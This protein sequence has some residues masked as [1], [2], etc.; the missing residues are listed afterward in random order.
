MYRNMYSTIWENIEVD[1][2]S[3]NCLELQSIILHCFDYWMFWFLNILTTLACL[4]Y[5]VGQFCCLLQ[6]TN[7]SYP[8]LSNWMYVEL[9]LPLDHVY[10]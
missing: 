3:A 5:K 9:F 7:N 1:V 6:C 2:K 4:V 8:S 10:K